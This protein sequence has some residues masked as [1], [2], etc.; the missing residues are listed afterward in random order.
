MDLSIYH[1]RGPFLTKTNNFSAV[2]K[3]T[4]I[5]TNVPTVISVYDDFLVT[6]PK[7]AKKWPLKAGFGLVL[8]LRRFILYGSTQ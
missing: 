3:I 7:S 5:N 1:I 8:V 2:S 6:Y 4:R